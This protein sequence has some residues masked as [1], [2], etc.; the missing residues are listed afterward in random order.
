[1]LCKAT[2]VCTNESR[3][4]SQMIQPQA[5]H[6]KLK[7]GE[8]CS[9]FPSSSSQQSQQPGTSS[10]PPRLKSSSKGC[11]LDVQG[12]LHSN[13]SC[14]LPTPLSPPNGLGGGSPTHS[15]LQPTSPS[16]PSRRHLSLPSVSVPVYVPVYVPVS[17][18]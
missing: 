11:D 7:V 10:P 14:P 1:M 9:S 5:R 16:S 2:A 8:D 15:L 12:L 3:V 13:S 4:V 6:W 18:Y 17:V